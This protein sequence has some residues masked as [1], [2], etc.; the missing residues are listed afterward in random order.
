MNKLQ[1][2]FH[3]GAIGQIVVLDHVS[4]DENH[5]LSIYEQPTFFR[6]DEVKGDG[7]SWHTFYNITH[8]NSGEV[9]EDYDGDWLADIDIWKDWKLGELND[10]IAA[11]ER[12]IRLLQHDKT[13]LMEVLGNAKLI[14]T[15]AIVKENLTC[16]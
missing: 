6:I 10:K 1:H 2:I 13:L 9:I 4:L 7:R 14:T 12:Q 8:L 5:V 15:E 16:K 11:Q 3:H